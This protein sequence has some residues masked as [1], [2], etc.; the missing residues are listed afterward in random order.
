MLG[1]ALDRARVAEMNLDPVDKSPLRSLLQIKFKQGAF[2][3]VEVEKWQERKII[4][5]KTLCHSVGRNWKQVYFREGH[6][7]SGFVL[8]WF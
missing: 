7:E 5:C 2:G 6:D 8:S 3:T 4:V 1:G